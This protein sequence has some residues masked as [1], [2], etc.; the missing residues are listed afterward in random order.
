MAIVSWT[1]YLEKPQYLALVREASV[2]AHL[3]DLGHEDLVFVIVIDIVIVIVI[4][5]DYNDLQESHY[6]L[7]W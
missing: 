5:E 1:K 6:S 2:D 3:L 7:Q 4:V